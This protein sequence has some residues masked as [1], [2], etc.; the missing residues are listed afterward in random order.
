MSGT[1]SPSRPAPAIDPRP[2]ADLVIVAHGER[3]GRGDNAAL[4]RLAAR[5]ARAGGL[6]VV[7]A[8]VLKGGPSLEAA[9]HAARGGAGC[10]YPLFMS[11]GYYVRTAIPERLRRAGKAI[12]V[13]RPFGLEPGL[14]KVIA[15]VAARAL[16]A[17]DHGPVAGTLL[18]VGHGSSKSDDS[19]AATDWQA[20][21]VRSLGAFDEVRTA[22]LENAPIL[23]DALQRLPPGP[24]A[25][26]GLFSGEGLHAG[27]DVPAAI[28]LTGRSDI[29]YAGPI[30][31]APEAAALIAASVRAASTAGAWSGAEP[32]PPGRVSTHAALTGMRAGLSS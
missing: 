15:R 24:C 8:G 5:T 11:D 16:G 29:R 21:R 2:D 7:H 12:H 18:L 26:V 28:R 13:H 6:G 31:T 23:A 20:A 17:R 4:L 19:R 30:G 27:E 10:I 3:G 9:L 22:Y 14:A 1:R 32:I 25:V